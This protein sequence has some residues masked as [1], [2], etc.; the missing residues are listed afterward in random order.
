MLETVGK[1]ILAPLLCEFEST[2]F[3]STFHCKCM[4]QRIN[5]YVAV[6]MFSCHRPSLKDSLASPGVQTILLQSH[7]A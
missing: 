4:I 1:T 7:N 2:Y 6:N 3:Y 5:V